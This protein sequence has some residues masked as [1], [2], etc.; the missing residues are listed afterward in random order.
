MIANLTIEEYFP[1][2]TELG[3]DCSMIN[4]QRIQQL[5]LS[6][7]PLTKGAIEKSIAAHLLFL[8]NG[9]AGGQWKTIHLKG[10][11]LALYFGEE[12]NKGKQANFELQQI[13]SE[14]ALRNVVLPFS[15]FCSSKI[16][17]VDFSGADLSYSILTDVFSKYANFSNA[18]LAYTDFTRGDFQEANF[19]NA[20]LIG[21]DFENCNLRGANFKGANL[22]QARFP[23]A[24]LKDAIF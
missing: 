11:V 5:V 3:A 18:Q 1:Y 4:R 14:I 22:R 23:G 19:R 20:N 8:E 9:G 7:K 13:P 15:N 12:V 2:C 21:A 17:K 24:I 16:E 6:N 10:I